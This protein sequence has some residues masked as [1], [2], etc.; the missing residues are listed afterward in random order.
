M[1]HQTLPLNAMIERE[2]DAMWRFALRLTENAENARMLVGK[3]R[4]RANEQQCQY[5][6]AVPD[7]A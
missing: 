6:S 7:L 1:E 5:A 2:L 4:T 3:T